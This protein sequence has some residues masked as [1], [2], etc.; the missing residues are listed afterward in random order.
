[1]KYFITRFALILCAGIAGFA[2]GRVSEHS[3]TIVTVPAHQASQFGVKLTDTGAVISPVKFVEDSTES[4]GDKQYIY[5]LAQDGRVLLRHNDD[6]T[7]LPLIK[8]VQSRYNQSVYVLYSGSDSIVMHAYYLPAGYTVY[9][10]MGG[11]VRDTTVFVKYQDNSVAIQPATD[12]YL[13]KK[14]MR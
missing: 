12:I 14:L 10:Q 3:D 4:T 13:R 2:A 1:M 11:H 9:F 5:V 7:D 8:A 6:T